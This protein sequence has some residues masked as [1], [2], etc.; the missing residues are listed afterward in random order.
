MVSDCKRFQADH[1]HLITDD[2]CKYQRCPVEEY[3]GHDF[4]L[5]RTT[6]AAGF[7]TAIG[8][9]KLEALTDA[10]N[11]YGEITLYVGDD[12]LIHGM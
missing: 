8:L 5:T 7:G 10:A 3:A 9:R 1:G 4:W 6:T 11:K 12:V 2:N